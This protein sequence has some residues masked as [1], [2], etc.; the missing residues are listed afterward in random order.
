MLHLQS[1][2]NIDSNVNK[3]NNVED[4]PAVDRSNLNC[5]EPVTD[6]DNENDKCTWKDMNLSDTLRHYRT[7]ID[8]CIGCVNHVFTLYTRGILNENCN[9]EQLL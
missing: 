2:H 6:D 3:S 4:K 9:I 1:P 7:Q 5:V 8:K